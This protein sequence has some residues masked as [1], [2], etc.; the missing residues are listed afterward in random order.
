V[1]GP[2]GNHYRNVEA[3]KLESGGLLLL[4]FQAEAAGASYADPV[5]TLT[6]LVTSL[7]GVTVTNPRLMTPAQAALVNGVQSTGLILAY[8]SAAPILPLADSYRI[9][10]TATGNVGTAQFSYST[11]NG[12]TYSAPAIL[13][14]AQS[15]PGGA[16]VIAV[17]DPSVSPSFYRNEV[18]FWAATPI[19]QQGSDEESD[20]RLAT[21]CR[22]RWL[23]LSDVPTP[24]TVALWAREAAAEVVRVR[25]VSEPSAANRML[26]YVSGSAGPAAPATVVAVQTYITARLTPPEGATVLPVDL[27]TIVA[28]GS[29]QAPRTALAA[30]QAQADLIWE[31]YLAS[32][33]IGGTVRLAKLQQA[34]KDAG[35]KNF[36]ALS[37]GGS[38]N[39][40]LGSSEVPV[41][42]GS[43]ST[44][45]SWQAV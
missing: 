43:L 41:P 42:S 4:N 12:K 3:G 1:T 38:P 45:L 29:V 32:V 24:G 37:I 2:T 20:A 34:V 44:A 15:L 30:V 26:V 9:L 23:T 33:D 16:D 6:T 7:P 28:A 36:S 18:F 21:R 13:R 27:H 5:D 22:A 40:V 14:P 17:N 11:D 8:T 35:A 39:V 25:V 31:A 19:I 10:I